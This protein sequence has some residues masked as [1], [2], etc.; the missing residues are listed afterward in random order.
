[1]FEFHDKVNQVIGFGLP[2]MLSKAFDDMSWYIVW[3]EEVGNIGKDSPTIGIDL[4]TG[5]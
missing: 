4:R 3:L 1:M 5:S 2:K